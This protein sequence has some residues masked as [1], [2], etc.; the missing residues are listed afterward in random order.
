M[1]K[2]FG[3]VLFVLASF[4][5]SGCGNSTENPPSLE[6]G[7]LSETGETYL[8]ISNKEWAMALDLTGYEDSQVG[9]SNSEQFFVRQKISEDQATF[10]MV[11]PS[12]YSVSGVNSA[13][14]CRELEVPLIEAFMT[15]PDVLSNG[16]VFGP[17]NKDEYN[18]HLLLVYNGLGEEGEF[19]NTV[20]YA[21][22]Y[23]DGYCFNLHL[24]TGIDEANITQTSALI[25]SMHIVK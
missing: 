24:T 25:D 10:T 14:A 1:Q 15:D 8:K 22:E 17:L 12:A 5:I 6:Y 19:I 11:T 3:F 23:Y 2:K 18:G 9:P 7:L 4:L 20:I 21:F 13:E 16:F